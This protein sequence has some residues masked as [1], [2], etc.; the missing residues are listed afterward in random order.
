M[1]TQIHR[2]PFSKII[3]KIGKIESD[4]FLIVVDEK[5]GELYR[6]ECNQL[7]ALKK[8][9]VV[10]YTCPEGESSKK[11]SEIER[12]AEF[13]LKEGIHRKA[14][15]ITFGGGACSD[16]G[17][18]VASL[19]LRGISWSTIPTTVLSMVDAAI[20]GKVAV[21]SKYGKNLIGAFHKPANVFIDESFIDTLPVDEK[22]SGDGEVIK[23]AF[24]DKDIHY[25]LQGDFEAGELF[26][27]CAE[28]KLK[29]TEEDFTESGLRKVLNLGHTIGHALE[30][31]YS[32]PHGIAV[33]WGMYYEFKMFGRDEFVQELEEYGHSF[34]LPQN[35]PD[36]TQTN[37][38]RIMDYIVKD[39]KMVSQT[40]IELIDVPAIGKP[41]IEKISLT[42]F[43][44]RVERIINE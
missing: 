35:R 9:K 30:R 11:F 14:H 3:E 43:K 4:T 5:V 27:A 32:L 42:D 12:A 36:I 25:L 39:K 8:H 21:N 22:H 37:F 23:Y 16:F 38:P 40:E 44:S 17:G 7:E 18:F 6:D 10:F 15:L 29:V 31:E 20:G 1:K 19:L 33:Y 26:E 2:I 24:L 13:F 41:T 34:S 28:Y